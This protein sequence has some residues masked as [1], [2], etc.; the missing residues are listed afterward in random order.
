MLVLDGLFL[1]R[2]EL[3]A[4]WDFSVWLEVPF[5]VAAARMAR[6]DGRS[7]DPDDPSMGRYVGGQRLYLAECQPDRRADLVVDNSDPDRL[8]VRA[9]PGRD[10]RHL[11]PRRRD[12]VRVG[13]WA[14]RV[15]LNTWASRQ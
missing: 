9:L 8:V 5:A 7:P 13:A 15:V 10:C 12:S 14:A 3:Q 11:G 6:R 2:D 4:Y 1:R